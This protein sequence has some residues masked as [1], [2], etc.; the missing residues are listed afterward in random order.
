MKD[1]KDFLLRFSGFL[2]FFFIPALFIL[3]FEMMPQLINLKPIFEILTWIAITGLL[4]LKFTLT[5]HPGVQ[6]IAKKIQERV[7][8]SKNIYA[9]MSGVSFA[10]LFTIVLFFGAMIYGALYART[11]IF[12]SL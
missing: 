1:S 7:A 9:F 8:A 10:L 4:I 3:S 11:F 5:Y 6:L 2:S 12:S